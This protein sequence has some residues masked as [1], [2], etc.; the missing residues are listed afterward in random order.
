M[1]SAILPVLG[2]TTSPLVGP[3]ALSILSICRVVITSLYLPKPY[4]SLRVASKGCQ[5]V[6]TMIAP[7]FSLKS[8]GS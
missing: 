6:A 2:R 5:P 8:W 1:D 7:T 4:S 3:E